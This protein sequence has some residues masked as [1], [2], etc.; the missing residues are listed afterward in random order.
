MR[1]ADDAN[2]LAEVVVTGTSIRGV[3]P[4]GSNLI[5]VSSQEL[6]KMGDEALTSRDLV[7]QRGSSARS[8]ASA[9]AA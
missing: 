9:I 1:A 8:M 2:E 6:A 4:V 5:S 3:A 7:R